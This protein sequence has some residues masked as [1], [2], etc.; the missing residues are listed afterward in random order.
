MGSGVMKKSRRNTTKLKG[1]AALTDARRRSPTVT[2]LQKQLDQR[3]CEL[4]EARKYLAEALEQQTATSEVLR[5]ISSAPGKL[6]PVFQAI[7]E[8]AVRICEAKFD[9]LFRLDNG[10]LWPTAMLGVSPEFAEFLRRGHQPGPETGLARAVRTK[11]PVHIVDLK[12]ELE[13]GKADPF[14][15]A[16]VE[17]GGTRTLLVVPMFKEEQP[18]GAIGI[19]RQE[20]RPFT[21]KQVEL[22][23]NFAAQAAIAIES[24]RLLNEL[25][26]RTDDLSE[27]LQQQTTTADVLKVISRSTFD[28]QPVLEALIENA[29]KLCAAEQ[30]FIFRLDGELYHLAADYNSPA[31]FRDWVHVAG[32][33]QEKDL[34][35]GA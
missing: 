15:V 32:F 11:R 35:S 27:S 8:N 31:G 17:L 5:V 2:G 22:V 21:D 6:E 24:T 16:G 19:F 26:Q 1:R 25:R 29:T 23:S 14:R 30:G 7:L 10:R 3:T 28:L 13:H 12:A 4:A 9:L 34:S 20:V 18:I 33:G